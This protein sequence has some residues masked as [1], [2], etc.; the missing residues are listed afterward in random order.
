[1]KELELRITD[2]RFQIP[3]LPDSK[4]T[5]GSESDLKPEM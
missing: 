4:N 3:K 2:S 5:C 1:L